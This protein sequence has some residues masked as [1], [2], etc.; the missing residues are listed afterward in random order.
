MSE[1]L[2]YQDKFCLKINESETSF[3]NLPNG[4]N[5]LQSTQ[6]LRKIFL[7]YC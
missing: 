3:L 7:K 1:L 5:D 4:T 2:N 6:H